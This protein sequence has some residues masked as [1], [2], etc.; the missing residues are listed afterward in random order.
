MKQW[1]LFLAVVLSLSAQ[2]VLAAEDSTEDKLLE[3]VRENDLG[4]KK[5]VYKTVSWQCSNTSE[6]IAD[7]AAKYGNSFTE[8]KDKYAIARWE[9]N[10][11]SK[12]D[13]IDRKSFRK[14]NYKVETEGGPYNLSLS[15]Y[16]ETLEPG[17]IATQ[18]VLDFQ[19][20]KN[21]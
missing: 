1:V 8:E 7:F 9:R 2:G 13:A 20:A 17:M 16:C 12:I 18:A 5:I 10:L 6:Y 4:N 19:K 11:E 3:L 21:N 14:I 15:V